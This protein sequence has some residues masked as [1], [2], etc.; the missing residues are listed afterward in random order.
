M[1]ATLR[2]RAHQS[3][4]LRTFQRVYDKQVD[5]TGLAVF[6]IVFCSVLLLDVGHLFYFRHLIFDVVP[7]I[8]VSEIGFTAPL[9]LWMATLLLL[10][11]GLH[12]RAAAVVNYGFALVLFSSLKT[13][14]YMMTPVYIGISF[15][16]L[17]LPISQRLSLD[18]LR[19]RLRYA[20]ARGGYQ[21]RATVSQLAYYVPVVVGIAFVYFDSALYKLTSPMWLAGLGMW[22]PLSL[23]YETPFNSSYVLNSEWLVKLLGY[24]TLA[25]EFLFLFLFPFR[26]YRPL[27]LLVGVGLH[28]GILVTLPVP[29]FALG[30]GSL[31]VLMVPIGYWR[32]LLGWA[33]PRPVAPRLTVYYDAEGLLCLR[34]RLLLE[35]LDGRGAVQYLPL[36]AAAQ[37]PAL[38]QVPPAALRA[39]MYSVGPAGEVYA[40]FDT[41]L[42]VLR[43]VGW[44]A[45][46]AW[47]LQ[48]PGCYQLGRAAYRFVAR[49][50]LG[51]AEAG[52]AP[53]GWPPQREAETRR[54]QRKLHLAGAALGLA[55]LTLLQG[56]VSYN[57]PLV[58]LLRRNSGLE[59]TLP[60]RLL[61][62]VSGAVE[63]P[64]RN[65]FGIANHPIALDEHFAGYTRLIAVTYTGPDGTEQFLPLTQPNGQPGAYLSGAVWLKWTYGIITN[66]LD[67]Q[68]L[69]K[70]LRSFTA[71]WARQHQVDLSDCQ[72][73]VKIKRI[74]E[75]TRWQ[76]DFLNQQLQR[77][78]WRDAGTVTWRNQQ[79]SA[80]LTNLATP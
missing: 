47:L 44:L 19:L 75:P 35:Q 14:A 60:G 43:A 58:L 50:R 61:A 65:F 31:Y 71:F 73:H 56:L 55:A 52:S 45:P 1:L 78:D 6:R 29:L 51:P 69:E 8:E 36:P 53:A 39:S 22:K 70:G 30:F 80:H 40:G 63:G 64:A 12:T 41:Y 77:T 25:F 76:P 54:I 28:L 2:A 72:F 20:D 3:K 17:F 68:R 4:L 42:Q 38:Q 32:R 59:R 16:F 67:Q 24:L 23:P 10:V 21:P 13:Y 46:L 57:T 26:R 7:F 48:L 11:L 5:G 49:N 74:A 9:L 37:Q 33:R 79:F 66:R 62:R 15:L 18:R 34:T 27:L